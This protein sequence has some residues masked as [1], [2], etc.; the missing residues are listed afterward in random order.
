VTTVPDSTSTRQAGLSYALATGVVWKLE[1]GIMANAQQ[2]KMIA[3][4]FAKLSPEAVT[5]IEMA[6]EMASMVFSNQDA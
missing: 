4:Q 1:V 5:L 2:E 6:V 3:V